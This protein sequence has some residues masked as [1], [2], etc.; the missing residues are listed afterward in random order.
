MKFA[1]GFGHVYVHFA[2]YL[3]SAHSFITITQNIRCVYISRCIKS[4]APCIYFRAIDC[5]AIVIR[6]CFICARAKGRT[7]RDR[8]T[9]SAN[10]ETETAKCETYTC[11]IW[12]VQ[13]ASFPCYVRSFQT[14][15]QYA[16]CT[17]AL[18]TRNKKR[19]QGKV[20]FIK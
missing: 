5:Y 1:F 10:G 4:G 8:D 12:Y 14:S 11:I 6:L 13:C 15:K 20:I 19:R 16:H 9:Q 3:C 7:F 18:V 17:L 2:L